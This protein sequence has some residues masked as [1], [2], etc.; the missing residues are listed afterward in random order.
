MPGT[1]V[2]KEL[3]AP[4]VAQY[5]CRTDGRLVVLLA[6]DDADA[7]ATV[8]TFV[9]SMGFAPFDLGGLREGRP[10]QVAGGPLSGLYV[11]KVRQHCLLAPLWGSPTGG[12]FPF[13]PLI[14]ERLARWAGARDRSARAPS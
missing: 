2:V 7:K 13:G 12:F 11:V 6:G 8:S 4:I 5:S 1:R 14:R 3:K 10:M 9:D